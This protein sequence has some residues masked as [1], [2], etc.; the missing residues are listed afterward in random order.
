MKLKVLQENLKQAVSLTS[1][2]ASSKA[3][4][5][6]LGNILLKAEKE[7]LLLSATNLE[8]SVSVSIGADVSE[9]GEI[10]IPAKTLSDL[11]VNLSPSTIE[12]E[13]KK[14]RVKINSDHFSSNISAMNSSDFPAVVQTVGKN[15]TS[16]DRETLINT[17]QKVL[18][19]ASN[20]ETRP[21]LTGVLVK[22]DKKKL[23]FVA[24]DGFRLS[25]KSIIADN[26]SDQQSL[27]LPKTALVEITRISSDEE[28][29]GLNFI[30][31]DSQVVFGI[32]DVVLASRIIEGNFPDY[33][34]I[35]PKEN[36][37]K[38]NLAKSDLSQA[39]RLAGVFARD[40]ANTIKLLV[41][42]DGLTVTSESSKSGSQ[43]TKIDAKVK[44]D[45]GKDGFTIAFNYKFIE[46]FL[47]SVE[48]ESVDI[49]FD[50][51]NSPGVFRDPEDK[52]F[53]HLIMP[54]RLTS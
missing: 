24:T 3:Q 32:E 40:S 43:K 53:L 5:P 54:V 37:I 7:S 22:F 36:K 50:E 44:G 19:A 42:K 45:I 52:D 34:K 10:T 20:D 29:I 9:E 1:R 41:E 38:I 12:L 31:K 17:L 26:T 14:E 21:V 51:V 35:I 8:L 16:L 18:Y 46:D 49:E 28:N 15:M 23:T 11:V 48:G 27:I 4:L 13:S 30:K 2:F 25:T 47:G 33:E 6:V 39:M